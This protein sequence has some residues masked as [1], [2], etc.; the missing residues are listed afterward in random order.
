MRA[1]EQWDVEIVISQH[2]RQR[3][4]FQNFLVC[5]KWPFNTEKKRY[6]Y[7]YFSHI[8]A[9][10]LLSISVDMKNG[11]FPKHNDDIDSIICTRPLLLFFYIFIT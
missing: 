2:E 3:D 6:T 1:N 4:P 11:A 8:H 7:V 5:Q 10:V 9:F